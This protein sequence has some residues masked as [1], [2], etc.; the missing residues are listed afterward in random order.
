MAAAVTAAL[1]LWWRH[2]PRVADRLAPDRLAP[3]RLA[4]DRLTPDRLAPDLLEGPRLGA[5]LLLAAFAFL[6]V[7]NPEYLCI[8]APL[9]IVGCIGLERTIQPWLL[10]AAGAIAWATNAVYYLLR[11]GYDPTGSLLGLEGF[12][13]PIEGREVLLDRLHQGLLVAFVLV[14]LLLAWNLLTASDRRS[15]PVT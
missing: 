6:A 3:D 5:A 12:A 11:T 2:R 10:V 14:T 8:A 1:V 4:P 13:H 9:A 7:S 15:S